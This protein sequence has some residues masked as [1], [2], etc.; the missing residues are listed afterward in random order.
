MKIFE[1]ACLSTL[2][3]RVKQEDSHLLWNGNRPVLFSTEETKSHELLAILADGMGGHVG[4]EIASYN[5]CKAFGQA[6]VEEGGDVSYRLNIALHCANNQIGELAIKNP[7]LNGMGTTLL[8]VFFFKSGL[9]W[10]SVGDS[11][12]YLF[13]KGKI[14][15]LNEDH[16]MTPVM[17]RE[18]AQFRSCLSKK[19]NDARSNMLRS[20][21]TG[22]EISL[23]DL[24]SCPFELENSDYIVLASDGILSL[25]LPEIEKKMSLNF[26]NGPRRVAQSIMQA[27][28]D[29]QDPH[30]D[31]T[32]VIV[33][34]Q[35]VKT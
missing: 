30:Q 7:K 24:A 19:G 27:I 32:T 25:P 16:S 12:L 18:A 17:T 9:Q 8:A 4:G 1:C 15:L 20:A 21:V 23:I 35:S 31:N 29:H 14:T 2:G 6:F 34:R 3:K 5:V 33:I 13:R 22:H 26:H 10:I 11:L 28:E